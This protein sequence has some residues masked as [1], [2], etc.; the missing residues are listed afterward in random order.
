MFIYTRD[1][2]KVVV[3]YVEV[4]ES[5][6]SETETVRFRG[7]INESGTRADFRGSNVIFRVLSRDSVIRDTKISSGTIA[8]GVTAEAALLTMLSQTRITNVLTVSASNINLKKDFTIDDGEKFNNV[9]TLTAVK[10]ILKVSNSIMIINDSDEVIIRNRDENNT[11]DPLALFG[12]NQIQ[13]KEN[14]IRIFNFNTGLHRSFTS[15]KLNDTEKSNTAYVTDFGSRQK[16]I[17]AGF[18]A[19]TTTEG[20]LANELVDE[21]KAAKIELKVTVSTS[22]VKDTDILDR[23]SIDY[24]LRLVPSGTF[25]PLYDS[26]DVYDTAV[27]PIA[28]GANE[29]NDNVAFKV[30]EILDDPRTFETTL[31]LRQIGVTVSDGYFSERGPSS[32]DSGKVYDAANSTYAS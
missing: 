21:F 22:I 20:T 24:P 5:D 23:V 12:P 9:Q 6:G 30:I 13:G 7:V 8:D 4:D 25:Y 29:L 32:Y 2:A 19:S 16:S 15:V 27:Y 31:K 26:S 18:I 3:S 1:L 17:T 28:K 10:N 11:K 14:I